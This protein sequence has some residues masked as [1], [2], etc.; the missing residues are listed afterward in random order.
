MR[1]LQATTVLSLCVAA[2]SSD[3]RAQ[4]PAELAGRYQSGRVEAQ[5]DSLG[6]Y[7]FVIGDVEGIAGEYTLAG[8]TITLQDDRGR[9]ACLGVP[10]RHLLA[11]AGDTLRF[12]LLTDECE[13]RRN[14]LGQPWIRVADGGFALTNVAVID[15]TGAAARSG[16][17]VVVRDG[18]IA[19]LFPTGSRPLP[20]G[21]ATTDLSGRFLIP[22]LIDS[23]VHLA[24]DP[25]GVDRRQ[26]VEERLRH[27]LRGGITAVRDMAGDAR[28]LADLARAALIGDIESP[29]IYYSALLSG[30]GFFDDERVQR[31]TRGLAAG[32]AAW[33]LAVTDTTTLPL[34]IAA[35]R[36][37]GATGIK[38]YAEVPP[39]LIQRITAEAHRQGLRVWSHATLVPAVPMD[40][41]TGGVDVLS[42]AAQFL[43][44]VQR[45]PDFRQRMNANYAAVEPDDPQLL[46]L[47]RA[48]ASRKTALDATLYVVRQ[49]EDALA[50]SAAI[51]RQAKVAGV[52]ILAGTDGIGAAAD[53]P[54]P[55]LHDE[56]ELLVTKA[57]LTPLEAITAATLAPARALGIEA[58]HGTIAEGMPADFVVLSADPSSDIRN[59]R[60][61]ETTYRGGKAYPPAR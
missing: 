34:A 28:T 24:T 1:P 17:T 45:L 29:A 44:Q 11:L 2:V 48:M 22:G 23:H 56:L 43:W 30:P 27:A 31:S 60:R 8:D 36:G 33:A 14:A 10:G 25:S 51:V 38:L 58:R 39:A 47:F 42:H 13:G 19:G 46:T 57:G 6:R 54:L 55:H 40:A 21:V 12:T 20:A 26:A 4:S 52:P 3:V 59:S 5:F 41:V 50:F 32:S 53:G 16:M 49:R 9:V 7:R 18:R 15:G 61:I 37:A 35:A